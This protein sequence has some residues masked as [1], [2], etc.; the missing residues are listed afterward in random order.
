MDVQ[1]GEVEFQPV[2]ACVGEHDGV[3]LSV[4]QFLDAGGHVAAQRFDAQVGLPQLELVLPP[5]GRSAHHTATLD[6]KGRGEVHGFGPHQ[7][8]VFDGPAEGHGGDQ[9][10]GWRGRFEVL[11]AVHGE[12]DVAIEEGL[13][14]FFREETLAFHLV[15]ADV[16]DLVSARLEHHD[17]HR[18][19]AGLQEVTHVV[20]LPQREGASAGADANVGIGGRHGRKVR[21]SGRVRSGLAKLFEHRFF[22]QLHGQAD[23]L[24]LEVSDDALHH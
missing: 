10:P 9:E 12:V 8:H 16:L 13:F 21:A 3:V 4:A 6:V 23:V 14:D 7:N 17:F 15:K 24:F 22:G 5:H 18:G 19:A 1:V 2:H 20:C 11:V